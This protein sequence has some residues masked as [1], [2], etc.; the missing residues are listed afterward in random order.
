MSWRSRNWTCT[1]TRFP[2]LPS[3]CVLEPCTFFSEGVLM[4][5]IGVLSSPSSRVSGLICIVTDWRELFFSSS[6]RGGCAIL[7]LPPTT[8]V[9]LTALAL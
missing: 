2:T 6:R 8:G 5:C 9:R 3:D 4:A 1:R 7:W